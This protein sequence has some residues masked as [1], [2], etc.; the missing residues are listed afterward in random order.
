[1]EEKNVSFSCK[2][3]KFWERGVAVGAMGGRALRALVGVSHGKRLLKNDLH[4]CMSVFACKISGFCGFVWVLLKKRA[5]CASMTIAYWCRTNFVRV[6]LDFTFQSTYE[7][8]LPALNFWFSLAELNL[9][10]KYLNSMTVFFRTMCSSL[11][12]TSIKLQ[13]NLVIVRSTWVESKLFSSSAVVSL[14]EFNFVVK[15]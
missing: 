6:S 8:F 7:K 11:Q 1:M 15:L 9:T 3:L 13:L 2:W 12:F 14:R 4:I 5:W 10:G